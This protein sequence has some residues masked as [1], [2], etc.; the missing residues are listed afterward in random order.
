MR[1]THSRRARKGLL[2]AG[3]VG[4]FVEEPG[5]SVDF[6]GQVGDLHLRQQF[7]DLAAE[8]DERGGFGVGIAAVHARMRSLLDVLD[9][10]PAPRDASRRAAGP[11]KP[12]RRCRS[13]RRLW[14]I[15][16]HACYGPLNG[17][18][19]GPSPSSLARA[20]AELGR[21]IKTLHVLE[22]AG[23]LCHCRDRHTGAVHRPLRTRW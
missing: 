22:Y 11:R 8:F 13:R 1:W 16:H 3:H 9:D 15:D 14:R 17:L 23:L 12:H 5:P 21:V 7:F 4:V 19:R 20:L 18:A 6:Q 2:G 10:D